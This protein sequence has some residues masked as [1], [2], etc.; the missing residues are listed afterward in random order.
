MMSFNKLNQ[1]ATEDLMT[2]VG[3]LGAFELT[4]QVDGLLGTHFYAGGFV[5]NSLTA[6]GTDT[7]GVAIK[8]WACEIAIE[9]NAIITGLSFLD[10]LRR[11]HRQGD[12]GAL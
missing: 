10:W 3:N 7:L 12:R 2:R 8:L 5:P 1:P 6:G 11:R 4:K 9:Q